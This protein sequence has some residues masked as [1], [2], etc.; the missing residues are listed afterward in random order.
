[1]IIFTI[2]NEGLSDKDF[3]EQIL[4]KLGIPQNELYK[5]NTTSYIKT[6]QHYFNNVYNELD[7][8]LIYQ[9]YK[10]FLEINKNISSKEFEEANGKL[11]K[12][13]GITIFIDKV[14][15]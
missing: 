4:S 1:M 3:E 10:N 14:L 7:L 12:S 15:Y 13:H 9:S 2:Q 11:F 5:Y 6:S 8:D